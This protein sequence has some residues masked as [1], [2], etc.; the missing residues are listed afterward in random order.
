ML[1]MTGAQR[2]GGKEEKLQSEL[3]SRPGGRGVKEINP[4]TVRETHR[5]TRPSTPAGYFYSERKTRERKKPAEGV[6]LS[7]KVR[8]GGAKTYAPRETATPRPTGINPKCEGKSLR[9]ST[10]RGEER[11][12]YPTTTRVPNREKKV[13]EGEL[14]RRPSTAR[15]SDKKKEY[16]TREGG[17]GGSAPLARHSNTR[18]EGEGRV[19]KHQ[20]RG[21]RRQG[22]DSPTSPR[23]ELREEEVGKRR[24]EISKIGRGPAR[25]LK[26]SRGAVGVYVSLKR[27]GERQRGGKRRD[28]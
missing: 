11:Q 28:R 15:T 2:R 3:A 12:N 19:P 13:T 24:M 25:K 16:E 22:F 14:H 10:R 1:T 8:G 21:P 4:G 9:K 20:V 7:P 18:S 17:G 23:T 26:G 5:Q 27:M 6:G